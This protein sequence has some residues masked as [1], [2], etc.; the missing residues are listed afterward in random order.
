MASYKKIDPSS[1]PT[2]RR[3]PSGVTATSPY[4]WPGLAAVVTSSG[5]W[6]SSASRSAWVEADRDTCVAN[7]RSIQVAKSQW[8]LENNKTAA[9]VPTE[10]DLLGYL[11]N[12]IFP[13]CPSGGTYTI[14]A[15]G[16]APACSIAGHAIPQ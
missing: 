7:L 1:D 3:F 9:D 15:I 16:I 13:A 10:Q 5:C 6:A 14:G 8:A 11:P 2:T 12:G 4:A